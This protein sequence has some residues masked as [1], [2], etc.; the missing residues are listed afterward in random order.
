MITEWTNVSG[1]PGS[2]GGFVTWSHT[3]GGTVTDGK[4]QIQIRA[5]DINDGGSWDG[6]Y[7]WTET[8]NVQFAVDTA[9][10]VTSFNAANGGTTN[11]STSS[12][13]T[14]NTS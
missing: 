6:I 8:S 1:Q 12:I 3:F 10:P 4:Y 2:D 7:D 5:A 9:Y 14:S 11:T 13:T